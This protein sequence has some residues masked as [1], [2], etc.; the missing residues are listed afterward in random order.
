MSS[1]VVRIT[2]GAAGTVGKRCG[3]AI[4]GGGAYEKFVKRVRSG[5]MRELGYQK[6]KL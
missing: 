3:R 4:T 2:R 5:N 6:R 1:E